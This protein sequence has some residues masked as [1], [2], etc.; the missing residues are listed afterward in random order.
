MVGVELHC[1]MQKLTWRTLTFLVCCSV[2]AGGVGFTRQ[3]RALLDHSSP[4]R[5]PPPFVTIRYAF[6]FGSMKFM[7]APDKQLE[8]CASLKCADRPENNCG[9]GAGWGGSG[10]ARLWALY[11]LQ[12]TAPEGDE[13]LGC[14]E[15]SKTPR[16]LDVSK[17][18]SQMTNTMCS[19]W[20]ASKGYG[21]YGTVN[22]VEC[23]GSAKAPASPVAR[24][25]SCLTPCSGDWSFI[26]GAK[27]RISLFRRKCGIERL[28]VR[29]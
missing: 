17:W 18:S 21:W 3:W 1:I 29:G 5:P 4:H 24:P 22:G 26:C 16:L 19:D 20:A 11:Q 6:A 25:A 13:Y 10:T 9:S 15:D 27:G 23:W 2:A 14:F 7:P 12:R 28:V 8:V